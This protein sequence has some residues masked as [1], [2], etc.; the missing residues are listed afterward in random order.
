MSQSIFKGMRCNGNH[1]DSW[2]ESGKRENVLMRHCGIFHIQ[3]VAPCVSSQQQKKF[4]MCP[5]SAPEQCLESSGIISE[6]TDKL[7][8]QAL[9]CPD[10]GKSPCGILG[11][12][13]KKK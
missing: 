7:L 13:K 6:A 12:K 10:S 5:I 11:F 3:R 9:T 1:T 2:N 4:V 8:D